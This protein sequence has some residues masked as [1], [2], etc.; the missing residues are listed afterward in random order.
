MFALWAMYTITTEAKK[1]SQLAIFFETALIIIYWR[2]RIMITQLRNIIRLFIQPMRYFYLKRIVGLNVQYSTIIS[3]GA[4]LDMTAPRFIFIG[5]NTIVTRGAMILSHDYTRA[6][7]LPTI[8]GKNCFL[9]VNSIIMP[10]VNIGDE[11]VI[12][13]GAVVTHDI[14]PNSMAVGNPAKIIRKINAGPYGRIIET[15]K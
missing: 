10:G 14:E 11:V 3:L 9:G 7:A 15:L 2:H 1:K 6:I 4:F 8:I 13:A 5:E 12:G